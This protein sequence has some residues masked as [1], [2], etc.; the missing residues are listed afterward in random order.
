[1]PTR[2]APERNHARKRVRALGDHEV[3]IL[4]RDRVDLEEDFMG[5][6]SGNVA[7]RL[8]EIAELSDLG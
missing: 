2:R 5:L 4:E 6:E 8:N 1:M 7:L 3:A